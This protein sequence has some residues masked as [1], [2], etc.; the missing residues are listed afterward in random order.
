MSASIQSGSSGPPGPGED[1]S[2]HPSEDDLFDVLSNER[3]RHAVR[4]LSGS[5]GPVEMADLAEAVA[6]R[7]YGIDADDLETQQRR[8][9]YTSLRQS[10]VP[11][12]AEKGI[13]EFDPEAR[14]VH[15]DERLAAYNIY[16][17]E[18]DELPWCHVYL[19]LAGVMSLLVG[20]VWAGLVPF[21]LVPARIWMGV[22]PLAFLLTA[23]AHALATRRLEPQ[24]SDDC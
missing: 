11:K 13:V 23:V 6:V 5:E 17:V 3:R 10:H 16:V 22:V 18:E 19:G 20:A 2:D 24:A 21:S 15:P 12:L 1:Q 8:R 7:E 4:V 14:E 9:V